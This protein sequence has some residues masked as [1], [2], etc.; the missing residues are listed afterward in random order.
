MNLGMTIRDEFTINEMKLNFL[1]Q[2]EDM[3]YNHYLHHPKQTIEWILIKYL[4]K[5]PNEKKSFLHMP[6]PLLEGK[7][8]E[9]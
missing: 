7:D 8:N 2:L 6:K 3:T 4:N 9:S 1:S 5:H